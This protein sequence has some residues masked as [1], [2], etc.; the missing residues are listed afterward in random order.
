MTKVPVLY[1]SP[2]SHIE[3]MAEPVAEGARSAGAQANLKRGPE[4][5]KASDFKLD[6][7]APIA[8]INELSSYNAI[9]AGIGTR[10]SH[11][12]SRVASLADQGCGPRARSALKGKFGGTFGTSSCQIPRLTRGRLV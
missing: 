7:A 12:S 10:F 1:Y 11:M 5:A 8:T 6:H 2:Y 3:R 9:V 4:A